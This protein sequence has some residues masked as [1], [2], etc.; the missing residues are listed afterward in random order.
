M[1]NLHESGHAIFRAT[2]ALDRGHMKSKGSGKLSIHFC[3]DYATIDTMCRTIVPVNQL[4]FLRSS[5]RFV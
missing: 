2:S 4:I 3:A 5:R 1:C